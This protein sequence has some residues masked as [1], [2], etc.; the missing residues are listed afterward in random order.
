MT[1]RDFEVQRALGTLSMQTILKL[2]H[3]RK[4]SMK[5]WRCLVECHDN[6]INKILSKNSFTPICILNELANDSSWDIVVN[7]AY[8]VHTRRKEY[9]E[10][11]KL[12]AEIQ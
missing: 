1:S 3:A 9:N 2:A 8:N 4:N 5:I 6:E 7:V 12:T 10:K 11:I